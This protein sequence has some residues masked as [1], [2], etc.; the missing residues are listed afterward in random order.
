MEKKEE[1]EKQ[2]SKEKKIRLQGHEKFALRDGWLNKGI[3]LI[4]DEKNANVFQ[5]KE[6]SDVFGIGNNMVKSLRY[7]LKAFGLIEESSRNGACLT[8]IG[9]LIFQY[10]AYFEDIFTIWILHS[11]IAK[12]VSEATTWYMFFNR[13]DMEE[14]K[15]DEI[16]DCLK[17]EI[18]KYLN[19]GK[20]AESSLS[21]DIDVL[22]QMYS[23]EKKITDPEDNNISPLVRL[24]L[25]KK[26]DGIYIK[27]HPDHRKIS[28]WN[29]L[30]ELSIIMKDSKEIS[31]DAI[32]SGD[33]SLAAIYQ[34]SRIS[35][36]EMLDKLE[37]LGYI[38]INRTAG[39]DMIY[40]KKEITP[41]QIIEEYYKAHR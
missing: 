31:I 40:K 9:K 32:S 27:Q 22:L 15:K 4:A 29:V 8:E 30:Y 20:F 21:V 7:W 24:E 37:G 12:N 17:R 34:L 28:E 14:F 2:E 33:K 1:K 16:E 39:L 5:G 11:Y 23:K 26:N 18:K 19:G 41:E 38:N 36:N 35:I 13:F 3:R 6:G 10:D 25:I